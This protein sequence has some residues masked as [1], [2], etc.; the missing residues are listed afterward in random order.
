MGV[1]ACVCESA[2]KRTSD[3]WPKSCECVCSVRA[4]ARS[5]TR[6]MASG[7]SENPFPPSAPL[8]QSSR[9]RRPPATHLLGRAAT[10]AAAYVPS[11]VTHPRIQHRNTPPRH[12]KH[13][14]SNRLSFPPFCAQR[15]PTSSAAATTTT[16][17]ATPTL[18]L[19]HTHTYIQYTYYIVPPLYA[20]LSRLVCSCYIVSSF[21]RGYVLTL[22]YIIALSKKKKITLIITYT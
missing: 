16:L 14:H 1:C 11:T 7:S 21:V 10:V 2:I 12:A 13:F 20:R 3:K 5:Q 18:S 15:R 4:S 22:P 19:T 9:P 8:S 6:S 17:Y